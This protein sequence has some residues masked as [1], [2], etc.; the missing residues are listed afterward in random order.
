MTINALWHAIYP[1]KILCCSERLL[2]KA[3]FI[4]IF[5]L[6]ID[7]YFLPIII[8]TVKPATFTHHPSLKLPSIS[9]FSIFKLMPDTFLRSL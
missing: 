4:Q 3:E 2:I 8:T 1:E 5:A 6:T 7:Q 9:C